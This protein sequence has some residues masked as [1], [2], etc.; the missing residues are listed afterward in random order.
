M[1][2]KN[3][4]RIFREITKESGY[5]A[6]RIIDGVYELK[7]GSRKVY[8]RGKNFGLNRSLATAFAT[9][10]AQTFELLHRNQIKAVPHYELYQPLEY[11]IFGDQHR[12]NLARIDAI[13]RREKFP[14][15]LKPAEGSK[16]KNVSLVYH[17]MQLKKLVKNL[18]LFEKM[19]VLSPFRNIKHEYR[20]AVLS[21]RVE[22]IFDK[23]KPVRVRKRRL[24]FGVLDYELIPP[25]TKVYKKLSTIAK[26]ATKLLGLEFAVVDIIETEEF[27]LEV[28][29]I[30][31]SVCL[32]HFA[33]RSPENYNL[34]KLIY[35]KAFRKA[36]K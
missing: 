18:F 1:D 19:L 2:D 36:I 32:G 14:L 28:L 11:A 12:R 25:D 35:K 24:V 7:K 15:V 21:G 17:K 4:H 10:K 30:N 3:F 6:T 9:N 31:S 5:I 16:A 23:I 22:L 26:R 33:G 8:V 13:I 29:E 34:V 27:G 20:C